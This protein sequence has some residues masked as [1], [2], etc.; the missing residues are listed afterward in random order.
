MLGRC[1]ALIVLLL[2]AS[3]GLARADTQPPAEPILR[4]ETGMHTGSVRRI[5]IDAACRLMVT[6]SED[7]SVRL[8][9]LPPSGRGVPKELRVMRVPIGRGDDGKIFSVAISPDGRV[10]AAGGWDV[11]ASVPKDIAVY[12][13]DAASGKITHRLGK[14]T[15][16]V[17]HLTFSADGRYLAATLGG[18]AG[19]RVW[20]TTTW[21]QVGK[22]TDYGGRDSYGAAF[23]AHDQ[24]FTVADD[25]FLRRYGPGDFRRNAQPVRTLGGKEPYSVAVHPDGSK[26][27]VGI[28]DKIAIDVYDARTL[29]RLFAAD[30]RGVND[31]NID[32][33]AWSSDGQRLFA[34]G[35]FY[36]TALG[37]VPVRIWDEG[38]RGKPHDVRVADSS[39]MQMLPCG[40]AIALGTADPAFGLISTDG[41]KLIWR[42]SAIPDMREK[43]GANFTVSA[44]GSRVRYGLGYAGATPMMF[45][46]ATNRLTAAPKATSDLF[47]PEDKGFKLTDWRNNRFPKLDGKT[48]P[49]KQ[50]EISRSMAV[51]PG[52]ERFVLGTEWALRCYDKT[53]KLLWL[54]KVPEV[55]WGVNVTRNGKYVIAAYGDGTIR[56]HRLTD[57][58]EVLALFVNAKSHEWVLWTPEGYYASSVGGDRDIGWQINKG[59]TH[60][61]EFVTA[62]RLKQHLYR[63]DIIKN[64]FEFADAG[65]AIRKAGLSGFK[66]ADLV[67]HTPPEFNIV[68]PGNQAHA[69][70]SP[71]AVRVK[72]A[73]ASDPVTGFDVTVN[74]RQVT[75]RALRD[76]PPVPEP[77][78]RTLNIPLEKGANHIRVVAHNAVGET[79]RNLTVF[80]DHNGV[81]NKKGRLF[82]LAIGVDKYPNLG[83]ENSLHFAAA[84]ASLILKTLTG[85]AAPLHTEVISKLLVTGGPTPPTKANIEDALL[86]FRDAGPRDTVI[87]FL[88]GHGVNDGPDYLFM[89]QDADYGQGK[90]GKYWRPSTVLRWTV[91]QQALQQAQGSRI[92][93]V[94][95]CHSAGAYS[96][97]LI[98]DA[99]DASIVVFSATDGPTEA[100]ERP[101]LGHGVFSFALNQGLL[102][103]ADPWK[104]GTVNILELGAYVSGA[105]RHLTHSEQEPTYNLSGVKDFA[106]TEP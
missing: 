65:R 15:S 31:R 93:F 46:L 76:L 25:G 97:R 82:V 1:F 95:T 7:K 60:T 2:T 45:D 90:Y 49:L 28:Y 37:G 18:G 54:Q 47:P 104:T 61:P 98:K 36:S 29:Q 88:A 64:A 55:T 73:A 9:A 5:G 75:P 83:P 58:Q 51:A 34:G 52:A 38:G 16:V 12:I 3:A 30:T 11:G 23:D 14:L 69:V 20:E 39:V 22:D 70:L 21:R 40:N 59:W 8:W 35:R 50:Y 19:M 56:W 66:L 74:G 10:V 87:L 106:L 77:Q 53:G 91:L 17:D 4:I 63:P 26:I 80:L 78:M 94:D 62:A 105:V 24:L 102:G 81:L 67:N 84:D 42:D 13:F 101:E 71:V 27:A 92:M 89:P 41:K 6:G 99:A 79:V 57:G 96:S 103:A 68:D 32:A 44:D 85:K 33:V 72:L 100:Q 48:I 86:M 43:R